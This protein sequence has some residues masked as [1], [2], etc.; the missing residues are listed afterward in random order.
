MTA[1]ASLAWTGAITGAALQLADLTDADQVF[2]VD[3]ATGTSDGWNVSVAA[4]QFTSTTPAAT[5]PNLATFSV[6]GSVDTPTTGATPAS[7]A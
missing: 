3:D 5:L 4:T 2:T 1:P 7:A 6:N